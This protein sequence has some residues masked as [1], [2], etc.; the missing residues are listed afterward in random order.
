[1]VMLKKLLSIGRQKEQQ[2]KN[3][4]QKQGFTIIAENYHCK[5]GEIDLIGTTQQ[6]LIFFEVKYRKSNHYGHPAEMVN[7][8]KQQHITHCAQQFLQKHPQYLN[9]QLQF[10]VLTFSGNQVQPDWIKNAF[11]AF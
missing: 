9:Y 8:K 4:L 7:Q 11:E 1:M 2:A 5:G 6:Q 10:D 3:W